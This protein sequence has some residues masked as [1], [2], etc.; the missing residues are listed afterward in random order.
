MLVKLFT[1]Q[2]RF[3]RRA[4]VVLSTVIL[5]LMTGI[6]WSIFIE[7]GRLVINSTTINIPRWHPEHKG[8]KI[9]VLTDL[10]V[11]SPFNDLAR[12]KE[13][14]ALTNA[15][16]PDLIVLL[17]DYLIGGITGGAFIEPEPIA[18][19]LKDLHAQ[20]GVFAVLGNHDWAI[21]GERVRKALQDVN[22][23]VLENDAVRITSNN[24]D[25]WIAGVADAWTR[26][27][28][29]PKILAKID[30]KNPVLLL[31]HNPDIFPKTDSRI[32]LVLAGHTHGGQVSLPIIG[33]PVVPSHFGQ[34]YAKG[35]VNEKDHQIF[36]SS[37][38]G[39][40]I[41]PIRFCVPPEIAVLQIE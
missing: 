31:T 12:L 32:D 2:S 14:V 33:S 4:I 36:I 29:I 19:G 41:F 40:S 9:A 20:I 18:Q 38:I 11:G 34:R 8:L 13:I 30:D 5:L 1:R 21:D 23:T 16:Q 24:K 17:G 37:G 28:D 25:L 10:H 15:Q 27:V 6:I 22:I 26:K 35:L 39:T 3:R 7:P